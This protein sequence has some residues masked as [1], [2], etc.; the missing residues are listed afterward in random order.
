MEKSE[1][2]TCPTCEQ[3]VLHG[4][5]S[6]QSEFIYCNGVKRVTMH[7]AANRRGESRSQNKGLALRNRREAQSK[8]KYLINQAF[9]YH[10]AAVIGSTKD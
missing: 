2:K 6:D 10:Q 9:S 8:A 5:S 1:G 4:V 3:V 7:S